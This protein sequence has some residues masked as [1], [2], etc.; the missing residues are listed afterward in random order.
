MARTPADYRDF[1]RVAVDL[2]DNPKLAMIDEPAAGWAYV[3]SLCYCG[4]NFTDG[5]FPLAPVLRMAGVKRAIADL[6]IGAGLWHE[7]GH[8]CERCPQP[9]TGMAVVHDY[10]EH[11]RSAE[12]ARS[13]RDTRREAGRKGAATRWSGNGHSKSHS[14]GHAKS[15]SKSHGNSDGKRMAD[16]S[17]T[18]GT[19]M[20]EGEGEKEQKKTS[21][22][23]SSAAADEGQLRPDVEQLVERLRDRLV[24]N[25]F[26]IPAGFEDWRRQ[27]R[28]LLDR[29]KRELDQA[30]R[31]IVWATD[32]HFW[33]GNIRSMGK[34][35]AQYDALLAQARNEYRQQQARQTST[36]T[37][38]PDD[39][40]SGW[41]AL[42][43]TG[44]DGQRPLIALPGGDHS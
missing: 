29:D 6:L 39:R 23:S 15:Y 9:M 32:H 28:L 14:N 20:P 1:I 44:T 25:G 40:I 18:D 16:A 27:A 11:Q 41:Q 37:G 38:R 19:P 7:T 36:P 12:E 13:L 31:L 42:K 8:T 17:Q 4:R 21:S 22:S 34:F 33:M 10:L 3:V 30:L 43:Q 5:A 2:P 26:K 24:K 35:R